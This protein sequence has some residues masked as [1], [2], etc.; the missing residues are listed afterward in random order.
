V[1]AFDGEVRVHIVWH[2][3][4]FRGD[5]LE[6]G[7]LPL[8]ELALD[9]GADSWVLYR[10]V[11]GGLDFMQQATFQAKADFDRYWYSEEVGELRAKLAGWYQVPLLPTFHRIAG[12][13]EALEP[14]DAEA[15]TS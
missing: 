15:A 5:K 14:V 4:P 11:E 3:N 13:G 2:A 8:A 12:Q 6:A 9:F 1:S 7:L 10:T